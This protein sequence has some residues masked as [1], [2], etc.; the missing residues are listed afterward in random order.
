MINISC[1]ST[2]YEIS[3]IYKYFTIN[4]VIS[5]S[6]HNFDS[7]RICNTN[8]NNIS[9]N[10]YLILDT[11][12]SAALFHWFAECAIFLPLF[13]ELKKKYPS[14]KL[15]F[16]TKQ[17]YHKLILEYYNIQETDI[18]YSISQNVENVCFFPLPISALNKTTICDDYILY[19]NSFIEWL[20]NVELEKSN[21]I[22]ILP[23]QKQQNSGEESG[24][25]INNCNDIITNLPNSIVLHTD[26]LYS[27][28]EQIRLIK[29]SKT[30][31]VSD[32][33]A[34]LFNGVFANNSTI[35][36]LGDMVVSQC[37]DHKKMEYYMNVIKK[38]NNVVFIKYTHGD[39]NN[40]SFLY[41]DL[42]S[43]L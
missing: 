10:Y 4:N 43:F 18:L 20:N 29:S 8:S 22:L 5:Y 33:S 2:D 11:Q 9:N 12:F 26:S 23:R 17:I 16:K 41:K 14:L 6:H 31:I 39:F 21:D 24:N 38:N 30:I 13:I 1:N 40:S 15:V 27:F 25:R 28:S 34:F 37:N 3:G 36:V 32:G 7:Y 19:A 35:I 42:I